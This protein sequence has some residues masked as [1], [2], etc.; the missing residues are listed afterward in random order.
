MATQRYTALQADLFKRH[1]TVSPGPDLRKAAVAALAR[2]MAAV[3]GIPAHRE[4]GC[5]DDA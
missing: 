5:D 4:D 1:K 2:L 3:V